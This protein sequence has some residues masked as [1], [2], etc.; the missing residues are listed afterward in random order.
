[1]RDDPGPLTPLASLPIPIPDSPEVVA[2]FG[3]EG[4]D[5]ASSLSE[6]TIES[7]LPANVHA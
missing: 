6:I 3:S 2:E 5:L 1:M 4:L 7:R